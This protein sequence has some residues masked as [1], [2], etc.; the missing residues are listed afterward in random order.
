MA[1]RK[2]QNIPDAFA[3]LGRDVV[4]FLQGLLDQEPSLLGVGMGIRWTASA[5]PS[6]KF[7]FLNGATVNKS[8]YDQLWTY[9]QGDPAYSTTATTITLPTVANFIVKARP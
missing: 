4:S 3:A 7:L 9:A 8:D 5:V 2:H 1:L 6:S